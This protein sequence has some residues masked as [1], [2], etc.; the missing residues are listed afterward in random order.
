MTT[1]SINHDL[2][3]ARNAAEN[4]LPQAQ[5]ALDALFAIADDGLICGDAR[6]QARAAKAAIAELALAIERAQKLDHAAIL[7][8]VARPR[9]VLKP[10]E[11]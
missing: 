10:R 8:D 3:I 6:A 5:R 11:R 7:R 9:C 1:N 2:E 4:A